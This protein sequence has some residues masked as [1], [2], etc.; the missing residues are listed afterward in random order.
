MVLLGLLAGFLFAAAASL[1][2]HAA[3]RT[4]TRTK[5]PGPLAGRAL[6]GPLLRLIRRLV[7][8]PLWL[9][10]W[11]TNLVGFLVQAA[12]LHLGTVALVQPLL[13]TQ[14]LFAMPLSTAWARRWPRPIEWLG[15]V[16]VSAGVAVFLSVR[17]VAPM[18][19]HTDRL[20]V[21]AALVVV[22]G[23]VALLSFA[24]AGRPPLVRATVVSVAAGLCFAMSAVLMKLTAEDLLE[25]G[26]AAT[27]V[28]WPGYILAVTTLSG[29]LLEQGAFATGSL[30]AAVAAMT[31]TNPVA[32]YLLGVM[33]FRVTPPTG[34]G[35]LAAL[36]GSAALL[37]IGVS[38]LARS[39]SIRRPDAVGDTA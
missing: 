22:A 11:C 9:V 6:V 25:R 14:L 2:Q 19:G 15:A 28:D 29:L 3:R 30:S 26:V 20:R 21:L 1:Q 16:A 23:V 31:I 13:V 36:A 17:S 5:N 8:D 34:P 38:A 33:L 32:S 7:R 24:S 12:A 10:G 18:N 35:A 4:V 39:P 27:A 37:F